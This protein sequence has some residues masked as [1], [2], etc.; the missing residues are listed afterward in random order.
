MS[1]NVRKLI[2]KTLC[3]LVNAKVKVQ[4]RK[5]MR[6]EQKAFYEHPHH[7]KYDKVEA[8]LRDALHVGF[9]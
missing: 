6:E 4:T 1:A 5:K 2:I 9:K 8:C 3:F 7:G